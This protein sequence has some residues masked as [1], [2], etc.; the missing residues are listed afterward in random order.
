MPQQCTECESVS[1]V[2]RYRCPRCGSRTFAQTDL[3]THGRIDSWTEMA[4]DGGTNT[5][6]IVVFPDGTRSFG[7]LLVEA[8]EPSIGAE[9]ELTGVVRLPHG[10]RR[11]FRPA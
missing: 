1:S 5:F 6:V 4:A 9:V 7:D 3:P 2:S 10:T 8:D 11:L